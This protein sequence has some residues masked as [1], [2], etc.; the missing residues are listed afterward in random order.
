[1]SCNNQLSEAGDEEGAMRLFQMLGMVAVTNCAIHFESSLPYRRPSGS[2][3]YPICGNWI[4]GASGV[5]S[6]P[7]GS[8]FTVQLSVIG[9]VPRP[10]AAVS[11]V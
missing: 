11:A 9:H 1:M 2:N 6:V 8:Y 4:Y 5:S 7:P 3:V 10:V